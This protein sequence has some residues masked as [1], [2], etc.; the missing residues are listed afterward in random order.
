MEVLERE[1]QL[2]ALSDYAADA[3]VGHG[4][5]VL[6]AGEAGAGKST[7]VAEL[8]R[9]AGD[10]RWAEGAC[11]GLSTP[12]PLTPLFDAAA[13]LGREVLVACRTGVPRDR[14]F[15]LVL[16]TLTA[17][18]TVLTV[19]DAHWADEA[20][21]DLLRFLGR[22]VGRTPS[23]VLVT[24][25]DDEL[26]AA[27]PLR[28]VLGD[29]ASQRTTRRVDVGPLS[30]G[31]VRRLAHGSGHD[32]REVYR[33]TAG[34]AFYV[35]EVIR[36]NHH[37]LP[38]SAHDIVPARLAR[39][40]RL[41]GTS[42]RRPPSRAPGSIRACWRPRSAPPLPSSTSCSPPA[43]SAATA[44]GCASATSWAGSRCSGG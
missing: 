19:E 23:L 30:P 42:R 39:V 20:T 5:L 4:R 43:S 11:D 28:L 2:V 32:A 25:R 44:P 24:Y 33:L 36:N 15:R 38:P 35:T 3:R 6:V 26:D 18:P 41:R 37:A 12:R 29:L 22:R 31:A 21:L 7:V 9:R 13:Q 10:L 1:P 40:R 8:R 14:L 17:Q 34:N 27:D 16:E